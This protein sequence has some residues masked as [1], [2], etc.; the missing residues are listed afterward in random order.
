MY[1]VRIRSEQAL[2]DVRTDARR[3]AARAQRRSVLLFGSLVEAQELAM[4]LKA[5]RRLGC[6]L[7]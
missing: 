4:K 6:P 1:N 3:I 7:S 2:G 5:M